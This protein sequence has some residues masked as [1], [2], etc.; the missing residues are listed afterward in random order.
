MKWIIIC[1][2]LL[3][4][5]PRAEAADKASF[6][7]SQNSV[8]MDGIRIQ[9]QNLSPAA[10]PT[11]IVAVTSNADGQ[12][13][14]VLK[15]APVLVFIHGWSCDG[16]FWKEQLAAFPD[17]RRIVID[18]PGFGKS[19]KPRNRPY[20]MK[21][22]ARAV[23]A[24]LDAAKVTQPVLIGHSMGYAVSRQFLMD[25]P[26]VARAIVNVDGAYYI[27]PTTP[28]AQARWDT[29][30]DEFMQAFTGS[31]RDVNVREFVE[32]TFYETT[33]EA[34]RPRIMDIMTR[35]DA[36]AANSA[37]REMG[38]P[39]QWKHQSFTLPALV[40]YAA[41]P[42]LSEK[43]ADYMRTVFP[44]MTYQ[45][46]TDAGHYLMLEQPQRFNELLRSFLVGLESK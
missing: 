46:W 22:F 8:T 6:P 30:M 32:S 35:A 26:N 20:S 12:P 43:H 14:M 28:E 27:A 38:T 39:E 2:A 29:E 41:A 36:Y 24:V 37:L 9:Y 3:L 23:K 33:P 42:Y 1:L 25:Y 18:L 19:D 31:Q 17:A 40:V 15:T 44:N 10:V 7:I 34:L 45:Q 4:A 13:Q 5:V 11:T 21:F 16:T